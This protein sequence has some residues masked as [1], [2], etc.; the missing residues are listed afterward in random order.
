MTKP[1]TII[2]AM[3]LSF[4]SFGLYGQ[5]GTVSG[6]S[7]AIGAGGSADYTIGQVI[8]K[9]ANGI[10]GN[11]TQ[12]LQQSYVI[13]AVTGIDE[14]WLELNMQMYPNPTSDFLVLNIIRDNFDFQFTSYTLFNNLGEKVGK[15]QINENKT[16]IPMQQLV[17]A[18]YFLKIHIGSTQIKTFRV[19]KN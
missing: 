15:G 2:T 10:T 18:T 9:P 5:S 16:Y 3:F 11:V 8:F 19:I 1:E 13:N 6:G 14:T 4:C 12:G 17:P 7:K